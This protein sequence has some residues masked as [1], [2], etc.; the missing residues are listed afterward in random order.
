M[1]CIKDA[2][3]HVFGVREGNHCR[4]N[5]DLC[6][7]TTFGSVDLPLSPITGRSS[8]ATDPAKNTTCVCTKHTHIVNA[9]GQRLFKKVQKC[10]NRGSPND[11]IAE[12]LD[13]PLCQASLHAGR[14]VK[15]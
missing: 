8:V 10:I 3:V 12:K 15:K 7:K 9:S 13:N 5:I 11:K 14:K 6:T 2:T 4:F 1:E